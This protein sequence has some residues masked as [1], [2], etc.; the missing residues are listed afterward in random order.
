MSYAT[1]KRGTD[2]VLLIVY[3][4]FGT[5]QAALTDRHNHLVAEFQ[6]NI[7][8]L[9]AKLDGLR[10]ALNQLE[11]TGSERTN[12]GSNRRVRSARE[13][14]PATKSKSSREGS[15]WSQLKISPNELGSIEWGHQMISIYGHSSNRHPSIPHSSKRFYFAP[16]ALLDRQSVT[17]SFNSNTQRPELRFRVEMWN[18]AVKKQVLRFTSELINQTLT[19]DQVDVLPV[20]QMS[21][22]SANPQRVYHTPSIWKEYNG[23][24]SVEFLLVCYQTSQCDKLADEVK[25]N[26]G[27]QLRNLKLQMGLTSE[28]LKR[29]D[30]SITIDQ[31]VHGDLITTSLIA[32]DDEDKLIGHL[33]DYVKT[34]T[35]DDKQMMSPDSE[36]EIYSLVRRLMNTSY[37]SLPVEED[38][39]SRNVFALYS[40]QDSSGDGTVIGPASQDERTS[41]KA[42]AKVNLAWLNDASNTNKKNR[43]IRVSYKTSMLTV[44]VE[45]EHQ[46]IDD[47]TS[48]EKLFE[49]Q[50]KTGKFLLTSSA[51]F[52]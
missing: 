13:E 47:I 8:T 35:F 20:D 10:D 4:S 28:R 39:G 46:L 3:I 34:A 36:A 31:T 21:L 15:A 7:A 19:D 11:A 48:E 38:G 51:S 24:Q 50:S 44:D 17:S 30:T 42:L 6:E 27:H 41:A 23:Q 16:I 40:G 14:G 9:T 32:A 1:G 37:M 12:D 2:S 18:D 26:P 43:K 49:P 52:K 29:R 33:V 22:Y 45:M 25:Q 5:L